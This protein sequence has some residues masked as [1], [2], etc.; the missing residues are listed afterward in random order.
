MQKE[1]L[2]TKFVNKRLLVNFFIIFSKWRLPALRNFSQILVK[3]IWQQILQTKSA[4]N[5][6]MRNLGFGFS[7]EIFEWDL[8]EC[9]LSTWTLAGVGPAAWSRTP[10]MRPPVPAH[11]AATFPARAA[12][13]LG[14]GPVLY[15]VGTVVGSQ[16]TGWFT[17]YGYFRWQERLIEK[18]LWSPNDRAC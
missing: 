16:S 15:C 5:C 12:Q 8:W 4:K 1:H 6:F 17:K 10:W 7:L 18:Y 2:R 3:T 13:K 9:C 11:P 14:R